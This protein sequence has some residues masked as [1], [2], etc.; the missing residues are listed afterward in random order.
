MEKTDTLP[1]NSNLPNPYNTLRI[2]LTDYML[3]I[4]PFLDAEW[5]KT[6]FL[7][8]FGYPTYIITQCGIY[9]SAFLFLQFIFKT[10]ISIYNTFNAKKLLK[11]QISFIAAFTHGFF[12]IITESMV[13]AADTDN[14]DNSD[15]DDNNTYSKPKKTK[16][17]PLS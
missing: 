3:N 12:N 15:S 5:F 10:I 17:I 8:L 13:N 11:G 16:K 6:T 14:S 2:G 4:A 9:F 1:I 7:E